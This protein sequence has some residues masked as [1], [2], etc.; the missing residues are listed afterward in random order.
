MG[1][2]G[3][4][5]LAGLSGRASRSSR[6]VS[7]AESAGPDFVPQ[8]AGPCSSQDGLAPPCLRAV[9]PPIRYAVDAPC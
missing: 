5:T 4:G 3:H 2:W 8:R 6:S 1:R 9:L 7:R